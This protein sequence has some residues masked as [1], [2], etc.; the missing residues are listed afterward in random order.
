M[1]IVEDRMRNPIAP[2]LSLIC[3]LAPLAV[4]ATAA[5]AELMKMVMPDAE[6]VIG[7]DA[8][9]IMKAPFG[10]LVMAE[11]DKEGKAQDLQKFIEMTGFDPRRDLKEIVFA[12]RNTSA[13]MEQKDNLRKA[14]SMGGL[15]MV[16]GFFN[17]AKIRSLASLDKEIS[18]GSYKGVTLLSKDQSEEVAALLGGSVLVVGHKKEVE[19]A[20]DRYQSREAATLRIGPAVERASGSYDIWI[21]GVVSPAMLA[22]HSGDPNAGGPLAGNLMRSVQSF[23][24]GVRF[25]TA[26]ELAGELAMESEKDATAFVDAMR[27]LAGM[28]QGNTGPQNP[29]GGFLNSL[30]L[31]A[32][33]TT[34]RFSLSASQS[35]L[36]KMLQSRAQKKVADLL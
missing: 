12:A 22:G 34:V 15:V 25:G 3:L 29:M 28:V 8:D 35:E 36:E 13:A 5:D 1:L 33:G 14:A 7:I 23:A 26:V 31:S 32:S 6:M 4:R 10:P 2:F 18:S 19:A 16:R 30:Q 24:G 21:A 20:I 17:E 27:F 9:R 11:I